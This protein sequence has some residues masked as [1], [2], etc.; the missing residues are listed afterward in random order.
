[1]YPPE[2]GQK[3]NLAEL[4]F[5]RAPLGNFIDKCE[6]GF[7]ACGESGYVCILASRHDGEDTGI[8]CRT[9]AHT[10]WTN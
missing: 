3:P 5:V 10:I 4:Q 7:T 9:D 6:E 1:M 2:L 8:F